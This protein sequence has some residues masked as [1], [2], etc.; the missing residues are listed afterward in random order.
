ML[1]L[2]EAFER[3]PP[4]G[5]LAFVYPAVVWILALG[6]LCL[7]MVFLPPLLRLILGARP[8][9][10]GPLRDRLERM[11]VAAG[12][13]GSRLMIVPTGTSRMSNAFVA[14]LSSVWR[15]IFF[16]ESILKGMSGTELECVL[17]HEV[18]HARKRHILFYLVSALAFSL[19]SG[20]VH[21]ALD[22]RGV[23]PLVLQ[24]LLFIWAGLY[25]G[26]GFGFVSRRFE[27]EADL[28][29]ARLVPPADGGLPPYVG[30]RSMAA[31]LHRVADLN[32]VPIWAPS[33]RHFTIERRIDILLNAE[34]DP[35]VGLRFERVCD[36]LRG[37]AAAL[38]VCAVLCG[39]I[40]LGMKSGRAA[41]NR[42]L[43]EAHESVKQGRRDLDAGRFFEALEHLKK[44]IDGGWSSASAWFW[45]ADAE[46]ALGRAADARKS[47]ATAREQD[48]SDPRLRLRAMQ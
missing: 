31:T 33:W 2:D 11:A 14:G 20:L 35:A 9:E 34:Q 29:A 37:A 3:I 39:G 13:G 19:F 12:Y 46:R 24:P 7:L 42:A 25:W 17:A 23:S 22:S 18:T 27:T 43:L 30:A 41:G 5:R 40:I 47:E 32:H 36:R 6:G 26:L 16:T 8:M 44:G 21:E 15:Y 28:V 45:K 48:L 10:P 1:L 4:L 38:V